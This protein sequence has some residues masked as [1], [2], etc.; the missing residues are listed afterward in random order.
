M[1]VIDEEHEH[2]YKS[3]SNPKY[4]ARDVAAY[5]AGKNNCLMLLASATP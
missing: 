1:I 4:H 5:R 2:T 3:E